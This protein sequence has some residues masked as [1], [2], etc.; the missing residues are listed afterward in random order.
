ML[1][2]SFL[3][4]NAR[5]LRRDD[6]VFDWSWPDAR[7][8]LKMYSD[9]EVTHRR[10]VNGKKGEWT[11]VRISDL[12]KFGIISASVTSRKLVNNNPVIRVITDDGD[13]HRR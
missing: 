6:V 9:T 2:R 1:F 12:R 3:Q 10:L 13:G 8:E 11:Q 4:K 5:D 7:Y